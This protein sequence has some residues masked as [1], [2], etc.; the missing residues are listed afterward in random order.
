MEKKGSLGGFLLMTTILSGGIGFPLLKLADSLTGSF[1]QSSGQIITGLTG[2]LLLGTG[3]LQLRAKSV[4]NRSEKDLIR[5]DGIF[6]GLV[7]GLAALPGF[8][9]S[10]L[11][12][13]ALVL[14][15]FSKKEALR[16]SFL[17]SLPIIFLGNIILNFS[18]IV[19]IDA[20]HIV[21]ILTSFVVGI[22]SIKVLL[23]IAQKVNFGYFVIGFG[24]LTLVAAFIV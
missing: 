1:I 16:L 21:G 22:A 19:A 10:G 3:L 17:M 12:V 24:V 23:Y 9:R 13:S 14:R 20:N 8:S 18:Q 6:L 2:I 7:Q 5:K 4:G 11:T 15:N